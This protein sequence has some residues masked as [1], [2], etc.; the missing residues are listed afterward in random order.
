MKHSTRSASSLLSSALSVFCLS[1]PV[2]SPHLSLLSFLPCLPLPQAVALKS[3]RKQ[4]WCIL[5]AWSTLHP[6]QHPSVGKCT[7]P[8]KNQ[9]HR[10][11][12]CEPFTWTQLKFHPWWQSAKRNYFYRD[13]FCNWEKKYNL[14]RGETHWCKAPYSIAQY[15]SFLNGQK[16]LLQLLRSDRHRWYTTY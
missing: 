14:Y 12:M 8:A 6:T 7:T 4:F 2:S 9:H 1:T 15:N 3:L 16:Y 13:Q 11:T 5:L 10:R